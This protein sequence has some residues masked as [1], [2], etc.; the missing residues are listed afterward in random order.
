MNGM[1]NRLLTSALLLIIFLNC[2]LISAAIGTWHNYTYS[3]DSHD[4]ASRSRSIPQEQFFSE[5]ATVLSPK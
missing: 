4:I 2:P 3:D 1:I 5:E